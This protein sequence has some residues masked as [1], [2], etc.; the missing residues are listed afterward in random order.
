M[1]A[2][3]VASRVVLSSTQ[4]V[5]SSRVCDKTKYATFRRCVPPESWSYS[6][7]D[8]TLRSYRSANLTF[9]KNTHRYGLDD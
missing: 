7:R 2:Q 3:L 6:L 1:A 5:S 4:L 9:S 8:R